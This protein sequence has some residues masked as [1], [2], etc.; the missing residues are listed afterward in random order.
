MGT[1]DQVA[2]VAAYTPSVTYAANNGLAQALRAVAG[3]MNKQ[4]GTKVFWVQ[5][6]GYDTHAGQGANAGAY[7]NLMATVERQ[8]RRVLSG[9]QQPGPPRARRS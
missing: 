4:I 9:P 2:K 6:G 8:H 3:A 1:L 5:T 7:V